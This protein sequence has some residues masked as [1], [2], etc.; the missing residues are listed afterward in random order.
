[1]VGSASP[2]SPAWRR[3]GW[4]R[5]RS[6]WLPGSRSRRPRRRRVRRPRR[7]TGAADARSVS[8]SRTEGP[9]RPRRRLSSGAR[10][11]LKLREAQILARMLAGS[12]TDREHEDRDG[13]RAD[14]R[15]GVLPRHDAEVPRAASARSPRCAA[16]R[17][18]AGR[19]R[20]RLLA[21]GRRA[22][23]DVAAGARGARRRERQRERRCPTSPSWPTRSVRTSAPGP[24][25][26]CN[27]VAAA[28]A[29]SGSDASSSPRSSPRSIAGDVVATWAVTEA[30]PHD[31]LGDLALRA[32]ADGD[33]FVLTGV[34]S[35]VE[36]GAEADQLLVT[37]T[38]DAGPTQFLV[39][40]D[41]AGRHR[42]AAAERRPRPALRP[43]RVRRRASPRRRVVGAAGDAAADDVETPAAD[44]GRGAGGG[45]GR[46]GRGRV[47]PH[48]RLGVQP[49]LVRASAGVVP[50]DQAPLRRHED[51]ARGEPRARRHRGA[52]RAPRRRRARMAISAA[53][54]YAGDY[55][56]ELVAGLRAAARRHRRDLRARH[57]PVPAPHHRR[58]AHLRHPH[59][60][61]PA[62]SPPC[63]SRTPPDRAE[64]P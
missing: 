44:R 28:L 7:A 49:L 12:A 11:P 36:A 19:L 63:A 55:L 48:A 29:R 27:V 17:S 52:P 31:G 60:P 18:D 10:R 24:L 5:S 8:G 34:K 33:D 54:A 51:V 1:M 23:L 20:A 6:R 35:P 15:P 13:A 3:R 59:R 53:K 32:E 45:D 25:L 38:T 58:P 61:P 62:A 21:P 47:R 50:G 37:A 30:P 40:A 46:R 43:H 9:Q 4:S 64:D 57:P 14:R 22:G 2:S 42:H 26:P 56:A 39:A 16:L 41:A